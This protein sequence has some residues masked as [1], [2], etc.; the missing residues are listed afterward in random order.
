M[1][2][3]NSRGDSTTAA[4]PGNDT[5]HTSG[6]CKGQKKTVEERNKKGK[7][8]EFW[9]YFAQRPVTRRPLMRSTSSGTIGAHTKQRIQSTG[10]GH[11]KRHTSLSTYNFTRSER[12]SDHPTEQKPWKPQADKIIRTKRSNPNLPPQERNILCAGT[13]NSPNLQ[14]GKKNDIPTVSAGHP[15]KNQ[16]KQ[17]ET[18]KTPFS[19][20]WMIGLKHG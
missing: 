2:N 4:I 5:L 20:G 15:S 1:K 12:P 17:S 18:L 3:R 19:R 11:A 9:E 10:I 16:R 13:T 7:N 14:Q 8:R 6:V